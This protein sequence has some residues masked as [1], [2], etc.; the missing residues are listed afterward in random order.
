[1]KKT[2]STLAI[3]LFV[4]TPAM[5]YEPGDWIFRGGVTQIDPDTASDPVTIDGADSGGEIDVE[6]DTQLGLTATYMLSNR[7]GIEVLAAT[8]FTHTVV[9]TEG[10][11]GLGDIADVTVLPP[12]ISAVYYLTDGKKFN[13]YVGVGINYSFMYDED[14]KG[15]FDGERV[16]IDDSVGVAIQV[17][18]DFEINP[19]LH[20]NASVRWIDIESDAKLSLSGQTVETTADI[21]PLVYSLMLGYDF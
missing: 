6:S 13:P 2:L 12:T 18:S 10:L 14:G 3:A 19:R 9:A 11:S 7:L 16:K 20:F 5:A 8:P 17:G 4:A 15:S 1:M 21:D